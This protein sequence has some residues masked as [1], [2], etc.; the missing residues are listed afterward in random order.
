MCPPA[1]RARTVSPSTI[2]VISI[3]TASFGAV[4]SGEVDGMLTGAAGARHPARV[5]ASA[6]ASAPVARRRER[7][8]ILRPYAAGPQGVGARTP[9]RATAD[10]SRASCRRRA[11]IQAS[12][13]AETLPGSESAWTHPRS[14]SCCTGRD[15]RG[16]PPGGG[17]DGTRGGGGARVSGPMQSAAV[18]CRAVAVPWPC[19]AG[20]A[21]PCRG[22]RGDSAQRGRAGGWP[23]DAAWRRS[24]KR[25]TAGGWTGRRCTNSGRPVRKWSFRTR[26]GRYGFIQPELVP[27]NG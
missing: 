7:R 26:I 20:R 8:I 12:G 22:V 27:G 11:P 18:P 4:S 23:C 13:P 15:G 24:G 6:H 9:G 2:C 14:L 25:R 17:L 3:A 19:R 16:R 5:A 21:V 1:G 10:R